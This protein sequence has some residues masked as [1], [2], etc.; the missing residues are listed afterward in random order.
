MKIK[1]ALSILIS[2][3]SAGAA[4]AAQAKTCSD[5]G[6]A[7]LYMQAALTGKDTARQ[8]LGSALFTL[9]RCLSTGG[10]SLPKSQLRGPYA[11]AVEYLAY[12]RQVSISPVSD[13]EIDA[14]ARLLPKAKDDKNKKDAAGGSYD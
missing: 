13:E 6:V 4:S 1:C 2:L 5:P 12:T 10:V 11:V 3:A 14:M 9:I 7:G 8:N